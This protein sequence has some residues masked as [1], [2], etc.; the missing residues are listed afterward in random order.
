MIQKITN[1]LTSN[2][3]NYRRC[4]SG[5]TSRSDAPLLQHDDSSNSCISFHG[6]KHHLQFII[7][8]DYNIPPSST[9]C[10]K[11]SSGECCVQQTSSSA[12][13]MSHKPPAVLLL[14]D[15]TTLLELSSSLCEGYV[16]LLSDG[17][18]SE[19]SRV[20]KANDKSLYDNVEL[21]Y[22][23]IMDG[24]VI[25]VCFGITSFTSKK[26]SQ[27]IKHITDAKDMINKIEMSSNDEMIQEIIVH[28]YCTTF[29]SIIIM[30][31]RI[32]KLN[33]ITK[34]WYMKRIHEQTLYTIQKNFHPIQQQYEQMIKQQ[35]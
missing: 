29:E 22:S 12:S 20:G 8:K 11:I 26:N 19:Q 6:Q 10:T 24:N 25:D 9:D 1:R 32:K 27:T 5:D 17:K 4:R 21:A 34:C 13:S 18:K 7:T 15:P 35:D 28:A 14:Y 23:S 2:T 3:Y 16:T 31:D 33:F 30:N